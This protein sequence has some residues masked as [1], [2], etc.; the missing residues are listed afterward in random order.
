MSSTEI[1]GVTFRY[2]TILIMIHNIDMLVP[3]GY[4]TGLNYAS[5]ALSLVTYGRIV[6]SDHAF[7]L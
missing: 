4:I 1:P 2:D 6:N 5:D 7:L 3:N